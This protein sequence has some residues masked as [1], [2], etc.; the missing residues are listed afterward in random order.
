LVASQGY[1][2]ND[3]G[4]YKV[5]ATA[6]TCQNINPRLKVQ[7]IKQRFGRGMKIGKVVFCA[8][9]GIET[10]RL[11][12]QSVKEK[13]SFFCDGRM[14]GEVL[15]VLTACDSESRKQYPATLFRPEEAFTGPCTARTRIY[16]ANIAASLMIAQFTRYLRRLPL[17][18][19]VQLNLLA[20]ELNIAGATIRF[21]S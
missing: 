15:R 5:N 6:D 1:F 19:D 8:V 12:W 13:V 2:E 4:S 11:I 14:N 9:D 21:Q 18:C 17:D 16:C 20:S 10:R 3:L 7:E